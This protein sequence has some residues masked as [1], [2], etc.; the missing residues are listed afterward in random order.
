MK[1][2]KFVINGGNELEGEIE[3]F[4]SK[5][6]ALGIMPASLLFKEKPEFQNLPHIEDIKRMRELLFVLES[7]GELNIEIAKKFRA[8]ILAVGPALARYGKVIFP[9]PGGCIIGSRPIDVFLDGWIKMGAHIKAPA[10][11]TPHGTD[12]YEIS[13]PNGLKGCNYTLRVPSVTGTEGLLMTAVLSKGITV[14][15]NTAIEPEISYL[16]N[17]LNK[18]G[19]KISGAGTHTITIEGR[20]GKL[21][22]NHEIFETPPDRIEAGSLV[23]LG[24]LLAK[25]LLIKNLIPEESAAVLSEIERAGA[26]LEYG[27]NF[28]VIHKLKDIRAVNIRTQEYPGFP[29]DLQAP[30][31][32]FLTQSHGQSFMH[33]TIFEG[34]LNYVEDLNKMGAN[35]V[36]CDPHRVI[37][38]GPTK[39]TGR[40]LKSPDIRAGLAFI[41]AAL[42]AEGTSEIGNIY[43]IDRGYESIDTRL[44]L[45]GADIKRI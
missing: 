17:F 10:G 18:N 28:I 2:P 39:L 22:E 23:I 37:I 20:D 31:T 32:V 29:T 27:N 13:T 42:T 40:H 8:S 4:G 33:E 1:E 41:I 16:A 44:K 15:R 21:L 43:Q 25:N 19:A 6:T 34:R 3:V 14:L 24:A 9:H 12:I 30:F 11:K 26:K 7:S 35:I 38:N 5:N 45:L 36:L